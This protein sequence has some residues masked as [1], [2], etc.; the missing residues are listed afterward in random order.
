MWTPNQSPSTLKT[1]PT[2][3]FFLAVFFFSKKKSLQCHTSPQMCSFYWQQQLPTG[4]ASTQDHWIEERRPFLLSGTTLRYSTCHRSRA[5][6]AIRK[7]QIWG[8][9]TQTSHTWNVKLLYA[10]LIFNSQVL[11]IRETRVLNVAFDLLKRWAF[12]LVMHK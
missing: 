5:L 4:K 1:Q 3:K 12:Q 7:R 11:V 10:V 2:A 8:T 9:S 6:L